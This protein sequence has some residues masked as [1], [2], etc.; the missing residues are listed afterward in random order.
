MNKLKPISAAP[1]DRDILIAWGSKASG[2]LGFTVGTCGTKY[3]HWTSKLID[4]WHDE[5]GK[6]IE[7]DGYCIFGWTELPEIP[8]EI[9]VD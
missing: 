9:V 1:K 3:S 6:C 5:S 2:C 4:V 7:R 8:S